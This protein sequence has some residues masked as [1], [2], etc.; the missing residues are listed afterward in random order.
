MDKTRKF[1]IWNYSGS[2]VIRNE[3]DMRLLDIEYS[4][5]NMKSIL[6][7]TVRYDYT[8]ASLNYLGGFVASKR[9]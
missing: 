8:M 6:S 5:S 2:I 9:L 3:M 4:N 1:L 7:T